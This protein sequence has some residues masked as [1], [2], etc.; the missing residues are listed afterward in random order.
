MATKGSSLLGNLHWADVVVVVLYF[1]FVLFVG[2][3]SSRRSKK[4]N[5]KGYFLASR[6]MHWIPVG[7]SLFASNIGSGHFIGL[8][9][10]GAASGIAVAGFELNA[11]FVLIFLGW[12][13][14]PVYTAAGVYTMPEYLR[15]RF[16]GQRIRVYLSV[17]AILLYIFTKVSADLYAGALFIQ[18]A[19]QW[20]GDLGLYLAIIVL[21]LIAAM[22]TI[23]GGLTA[24]IWTDAVQTVLMIA[25]SMILCVMSFVAV[26]GYNALIEQYFE[27]EPSANVTLYD[28]DNQSCAA[29][30]PDA[31]HLFRSAVPGESDLP[32]PGMTFGLT[33]SAVWYWCSDQVIVQRTLSAKNLVHAKGGVLLAGALKFLPLY[34]L[35][36]PGMAARVL[37]TDSVACSEPEACQRI[38]GSPTGCSNLAYIELVLNLLP[39]GVSGLMLAV[40]LA[41]LMSSLTSIFNS[42]STLFTIDVYTRLRSRASELEQVIAGRV[43]V[44]FMVAVSIVW[45]PIINSSASSQLFVY[46]QSITAYLAP[47]IC[48]IYL[49]AVFWPRANEQGAFWGMMLG[50]VLGMVRFGIEFSYT[51]PPCGSELEDTRPEWVK[52]AIFD[53]HFL[54]F[55]CILFLIVLV[56][57]VVISLCTEPIPEECLRRLTFW[58]RRC[59]EPRMPLPSESAKQRFVEEIQLQDE[60]PEPPATPSLGRKIFNKLCGVAEGAAMGESAATDPFG[61]L[62]DVERAK[63][64][65]DSL[66]EHPRQKVIVNVLAMVLMAVSAGMYT[67]YR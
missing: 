67:Y 60:P 17:L 45:I 41:A 15:L 27:K 61:H 38:C 57:S 58:S 65:A 39:V 53:I 34:L 29:A 1:A 62:T 25:G 50:L 31:M 24:V 28:A 6:S 10:T 13:F 66:L 20:E 46:I 5:L 16:G 55:G 47:P 3:W 56:A 44:V 4:D 59:E 33:V 64:D 14:V 52:R 12:A 8:A 36:F 2:L 35:V 9:G 30:R 43:F 26:G 11:V 23:F 32:W 18:R 21:L 37:Y 54:H 19:M 42:A 48:A 49:L 63:M 51:V 22:F 7:A 40:M